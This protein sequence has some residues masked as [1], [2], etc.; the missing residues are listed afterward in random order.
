[1]TQQWMSII[2]YARHFNVSDMTVRRR[3]KNGKL[4]AS[5]KEGKYYI[6]VDENHRPQFDD[7]LEFATE[8]RIQPQKS[9]PLMRDNLGT[10]KHLDFDFRNDSF[11]LPRPS[12]VTQAGPRSVG[13]HIEKP[14][15]PIDF[16]LPNFPPQILKDPEPSLE[17]SKKTVAEVLE[18]ANKA[19]E[20]VEEKFRAKELEWESR[21][22]SKEQELA[23]RD[24]KIDMLKQQIE[25]LQLLV[26]VL[27]GSQAG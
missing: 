20:S 12:Q 6:P 5:L 21:L 8:A 1:M 4:Y 16:P 27:E 14:S 17:P 2:E 3:I 26:K 10:S 18:F 9:A 15:I 11:A 24:Q 7:E 23:N 22:R 13:I 25:D 19:M